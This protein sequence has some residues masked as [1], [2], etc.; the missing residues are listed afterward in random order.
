MNKAKYT[1]FQRPFHILQ[2]VSWFT[3]VFILW[4]SYTILSSALEGKLQASFLVLFTISELVVLALGFAGTKSNPTDPTIKEQIVL[5][6]SGLEINSSCYEAFCETC[7]F[8]VHTS[9]KHC[10]P[11]NRC[12]KGFDHHCKWLNNCVG[13]LNYSIFLGL[14]VMLSVNVSI[15]LV[16][17][18]A[19]LYQYFNNDSTIADNLGDSLGGNLSGW[20]GVLIVLG[21]LCIA[22][23]AAT[24]NLIGLHIYLKYRGITTYAFILEKRAKKA[25]ATVKTSP[26]SP[27]AS[28]QK[29]VITPEDVDKHVSEIVQ[30][31]KEMVKPGFVSGYVTRINTVGSSNMV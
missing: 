13:E 28:P 5:K 8:F 20:C 24:T 21:L 10:G 22:I 17:D 9:S 25:T 7:N 4:A 23:L 29:E 14:I 30:V 15:V 27:T 2:I 11:C 26:E 3:T 1:G 19:V 31:D 18:T 16:F 6:Q 12:V